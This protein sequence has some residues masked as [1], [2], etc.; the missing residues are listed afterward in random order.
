[1][2]DNWLSNRIFTDLSDITD[3]CCKAWNRLTDS[4]SR[5]T[6]IGMRHWIHP[7]QRFAQSAGDG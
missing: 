3:H 4:T 7:R 6:S 2:R 1:M 5:I